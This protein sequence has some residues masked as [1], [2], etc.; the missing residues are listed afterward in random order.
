MLRFTFSM[1]SRTKQILLL[2]LCV[3]LILVT[4]LAIRLIPEY[5]V[6]YS[7]I[8]EHFKYGSIGTEPVNGLPYW[9]WKVLPVL[10]ADKM[11]ANGYAGLGLMSEDNQ[12]LPIGV[13]KRTVY[14]IDRVW[15]NCA[16]C[17]SGTYRETPESERMLVL[18]MPAHRLKLYQLIQF[19]I[20]A[21]RDNRFTSDRMIPRIEEISDG[22]F[23]FLETLTY[24]YLIIPFTRAAIL[25]LGDNLAHMRRQERWGTGRVDTFNAYK[26]NQLGFPTEAITQKELVGPA[27][28][29]SIWG[30]RP[31]QGMELHWDGNNNKVEERNLSAAMGAGVTPVSIDLDN[32]RR[33]M[34]WLW[35]MKAPVYPKKGRIEK[36]KANNGKIAYQQYCSDCHGETEAGVYKFDSQRF[37]R[38]GKVEPIEYIG[39]DPGRLDSYTEVLAMNQ[40]SFFSGYPSLRFKNFR[41]TYGYASMP[42]DGIWLRGPYLHNGSVPTIRDLLEPSS[43]RPKK[44]YRGYDVIDWQKIGFISNVAKEKGEKFY[45][46]DTDAPGNSNKGHEGEAYGT[47]LSPDLKDAIVEYMKEF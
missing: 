8:D 10:Y 33:V 25:Q 14:G 15:L 16:V 30:Q 5:P 41:K 40:N 35:D 7:K 46:F 31:R 39:T 23:G 2:F 21:A 3:V 9:I 38:L 47:D 20:N 26:T 37:T 44:F 11:P 45:L 4:Y 17:H 42:L 27:D 36:A 13:S 24:R 1:I 34:D 19:L 43:Q 12:D 18:A 6:T 22:E 32:V 28:L 29:P